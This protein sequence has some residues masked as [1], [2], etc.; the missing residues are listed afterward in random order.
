MLGLEVTLYHNSPAYQHLSDILLKQ[1]NAG[2]APENESGKKDDKDEKDGGDKE[3]L[4][5]KDR[6]KE[7]V[8]LAEAE[9]PWFYSMFPVT[10][11]VIT[12]SAVMVGNLVLPNFLVATFSGARILHTAVAASASHSLY[13]MATKVYQLEVS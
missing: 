2:N 8:K 9:V 13:R 4:L 3:S 6:S 12:M 5:G 1:Q 11:L 7:A 10:R